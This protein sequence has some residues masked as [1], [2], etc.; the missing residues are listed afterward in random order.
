MLYPDEF[1]DV[2]GSLSFIFCAFKAIGFSFS[3]RFLILV[4]VYVE[5]KL[6]SAQ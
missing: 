4:S 5:K 1:F 3:S 6:P 2:F